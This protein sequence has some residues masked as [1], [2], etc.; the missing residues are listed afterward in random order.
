MADLSDL[1]ELIDEV[2][3]DVGQP[4][5]GK[6]ITARQFRQAVSDIIKEH[7]RNEMVEEDIEK[8]QAIIDAMGR[9]FIDGNHVG[10][11]KRDAGLV[12]LKALAAAMDCNLPS[13]DA[14]L[15]MSEVRS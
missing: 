12:E 10:W 3:E 9:I 4:V 15:E 8:P 11:V 13:L 6:V 5:D 7:Q 14:M 2:F 1:R